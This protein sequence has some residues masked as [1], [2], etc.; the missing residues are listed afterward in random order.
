M[1]KGPEA[2]FSRNS[3]DAKV[4]GHK[5]QEIKVER[6]NPHTSQLGLHTYRAPFPSIERWE[7]IRIFTRVVM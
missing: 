3:K 5:M 1:S 2:G 6:A 7:A 4:A